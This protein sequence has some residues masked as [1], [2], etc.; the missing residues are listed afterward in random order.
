[1]NL[2]DVL[3]RPATA[4]DLWLF[5]RQADEPDAGGTFNWSG[6]RDIAGTRRRLDEN[7]LIG[8][9]NGCLIVE[10]ED[11]VAGSVVWSKVTYG[12]PTWCCWNIGISLL[13]EFRGK[14]FGTGA[15][16]LLVSYLF[17]ISQFDR[18]EAYTDVENVAE[19][20]ALDKVGFK[21]EGT[22]RSAQFRQG[23]WRDLF[24]Y[25]VLRDEFKAISSTSAPRT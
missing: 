9:D 18:I 11:T 2:A 6:Y 16:R 19:Q 21:Q 14:G 5:E 12:M 3:L 4:A 22:I 24:L 15:Q 23:R 1:M 10:H 8:P 17:D 20:R 25:S 7:R 13:P